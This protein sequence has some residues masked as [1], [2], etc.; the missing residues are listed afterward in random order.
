MFKR[1]S[2]LI[3][4]VCLIFVIAGCGE[5]IKKVEIRHRYSRG[6]VNNLTP[7]ELELENTLKKAAKLE[8]AK[9]YAKGMFD[10]AYIIAAEHENLGFT[11]YVKGND[12]VV[13]RGLDTSKEPTL[14]IPLSDDAI[15]NTVRFFEDGVIDD[16][17][18]FLI[19]NGTF[20]PA[21][22]A[23]YRIPEIQSRWIRKFMKLEG[24]MHVTLLNEKKY[25]YQGKVVKNELSV[26]RVD[27][28]WLVFNGLEGL[29]VSR[30]ALS[31]KD[32]VAMYKLIMRDLKR[33]KS[34]SEKMEIMNQFGKIR[35]RCLV[36]K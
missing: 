28:E 4:A 32:A 16:R 9:Q 15:F 31:A 6:K 34:V 27:N 20:K 7:Q 33:A 26:V 5:R 30:M 36:K 25:E 11:V 17:E 29:P 1:S 2:W 23:S 13:E 19:V 12:V 3:L 35:S 8:A 10:V 21:W 24:L 18:E 14:V 22:E